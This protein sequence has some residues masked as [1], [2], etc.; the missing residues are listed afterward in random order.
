VGGA[1]PDFVAFRPAPQPV[2]GQ[3]TTANL[4]QL[5]AALTQAFGAE[6]PI[7]LDGVLAPTA[8][9]VTGYAC[10]GAVAGIVLDHLSDASPIAAAAADAQ[11]GNA[12]CPGLALPVVATT[13]TF[14]GTAS[15]PVQLACER[16]CLY[17]VTLEDARSR[18]VAATRGALTGG[19]A[20]A[21]IVLPVAK[22]PAGGYR[23]DVRLVSRTNPGAVARSVSS[24][25]AVG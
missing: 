9:T 14:P 10:T 11:R 21:A 8:G 20:P 25:V 15:E 1:A 7:L 16:D 13:L 19:A 24:P 3:W 17:L 23:F 12:V 5:K 22:L 4:T 2:A 6:P 18:P